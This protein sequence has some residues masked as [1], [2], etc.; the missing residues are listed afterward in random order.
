MFIQ[1][2]ETPNPNSIK[3]LPGKVLLPTGTMD[4]P[5]IRAANKSPLAK[6]LFEISGITGVYFG[7]DFLTV[8]KGDEDLD[9]QMIKPQIFAVI[10][11]FFSSG[12]PVMDDQAAASEPES[13]DGK[14]DELVSLIKEL[15]ETRIRPTVQEDGGDIVFKGFEEGVVKVKLQGSCTSC[16]SSSVTLKRGVQNMLQYYVPEVMGVIQVE[17]EV[18]DISKQEFE[19]FE[20]TRE[21]TK[22]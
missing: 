17:D 4:F 22:P 19:K 20:K 14:E 15:I 9:W 16:P 10:M 12:L 7:H 13:F 18:D 8:T 3:L 5:N 6:K 2:Q 21:E 11:D 1:S